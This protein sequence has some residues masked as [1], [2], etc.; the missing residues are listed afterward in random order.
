MA[1]GWLGQPPKVV[2]SRDVTDPKASELRARSPGAPA[3]REGMRFQQ[4]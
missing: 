1:R 4:T 3:T 2:V